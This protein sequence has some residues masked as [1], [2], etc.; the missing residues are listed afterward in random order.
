MSKKNLI[1]DY[2]IT[3]IV[4]FAILLSAFLINQTLAR[5]ESKE[6]LRYYGNEISIIYKGNNDELV[7]IKT[8]YSKIKDLRVSIY[9]KNANEMLEVNPEEKEGA[10][11]D[12]KDELEKYSNSYYYKDSQ[13]L[14][15]EVL[16][17]VLSRD[18]VY[19]RVGIPSGVIIN[20]SMNLLLY[21]SI[22]LICFD[23]AYFAIRYVN[24]KK[25]MGTLRKGLEHLQ[26]TLGIEEKENN[27]DGL[28]MLSETIAKTDEALKEQLSLLRKENL[29]LDYILDSMEEGVIVIDD[30]DNVILV[31][32]YVLCLSK[33]KKEDVIDKNYAYLL[34]GD[35]FK[36]KADEAKN[37][38]MSYLDLTINGRIYYLMINS[39][40]LEWIGDGKKR[41]LGIAM[42]DIT[43]TRMNE[44]MKRE[45]FQNASHELK[46]PLTTIIGYSE[47]LFN[48]IIKDEEEVSKAEQAIT[49][50]SKR[51]Q[52]ILN[53]MF[54]LFSLESQFYNDKKEQVDVKQA[55]IDSTT[56]LSFLADRKNIDIEL[57]LQDVTINGYKTDIEKLVN[58]LLSNA[59]RYG[60]ENGNIKLTLTPEYFS[61]QDDGIG[62]K[63]K[64]LNRIFERFYRVDKSRSKQDGGTG[65]GLAIVK[66]ICINN[67][68]RIDVKSKIN[69]GS[70]FTIYF[71]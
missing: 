2:I 67:G 35:E 47:L 14:N 19:I 62:I 69:E 55:V 27:D 65:L 59:I 66:H 44:K 50:E 3:F 41:G 6:T 26:G 4:S 9:D 31:N 34:F 15:C 40:D 36:K 29:K 53:D 18:D 52:S 30:K 60:K 16:Y 32:K 43:Q 7:E 54:D 24:W 49:K 22:I 63:E 68:Y 37:N 70:T 51:M 46:T 8:I 38:S 23:G 33:R 71:K 42:V 12:R 28:K 13:T 39:I 48:D 20:S 25:E 1:I 11:E 21:G 5:N 58:N 56:L 10:K 57:S 61:C 64:D 45:F 17:Y